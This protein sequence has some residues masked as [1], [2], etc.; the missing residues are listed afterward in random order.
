MNADHEVHDGIWADGPHAGRP[1]TDHEADMHAY[2]AAGDRLLAAKADLQQ[3]AAEG[4]WDA[5]SAEYADA[6]R[7]Y[8]AVGREALGEP[9]VAAPD[10][11]LP[12]DANDSASGRAR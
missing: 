3:A 8:Q 7:R 1:L 10:W 11:S 4:R 12:A 6:S 5:A 2:Y 9:Q